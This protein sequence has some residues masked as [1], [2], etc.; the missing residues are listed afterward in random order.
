MASNRSTNLLCA[1]AIFLIVVAGCSGGGGE[2]GDDT[3]DRA[4][5]MTE[6]STEE[7][8]QSRA[9]AEDIAQSQARATAEAHELGRAAA[10]QLGQRLKSELMAA[11][12]QG[13]QVHALSVC[14][15]EGLALADSV[16][17]ELGV[18]VRRV[19]SRYRNPANRPDAVEAAVLAVFDARPTLADTLVVLA[20]EDGDKGAH[21]PGYLF[22]SPIRISSALCLGCHGDESDLD[23]E[24]SERLAELYPE[25]RATGFATGDLRGAFAV[26]ISDVGTESESRH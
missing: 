11:T 26:R 14:N 10:K 9:G 19:S 3:A 12:G 13:G 8:A 23:P 21:E 22:M 15:L 5:D 16:S 7:A 25:D 17:A 4:R 6:G 1:T 24:V 20:E 18:S 2:S